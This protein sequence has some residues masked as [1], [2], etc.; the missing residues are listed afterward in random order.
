MYLPDNSYIASGYIPRSGK[1]RS[2]RSYIFNFLRILH[3]VFPLGN[4]K[5]ELCDL[6]V[7]KSQPSPQR[8]NLL[9]VCEGHGKQGEA[10]PQVSGISALVLPSPLSLRG[11]PIS[12]AGK[13][14]EES[15][16]QT[17]LCISDA[18]ISD[19]PAQTDAISLTPSPPAW[20]VGVWI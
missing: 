2:Y 13:L 16:L 9:S 3:T 14:K 5:T 8:I 17:V 11:G 7:E 4:Y 1:A 20:H 15:S 19:F 10:Y 6:T 12:Q 18:G